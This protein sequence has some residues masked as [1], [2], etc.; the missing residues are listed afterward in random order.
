MTIQYAWF[1]FLRAKGPDDC[2][3][4]SRIVAAGLCRHPC[5]PTL[6]LIAG[7]IAIKQDDMVVAYQ[8][9]RYCIS[10]CNDD[11]FF[12][13][14]L[15]VIYYK[16]GQTQDA[17]IAFQRALYLKGEMSEP[18]LNIGLIFEQQGDSTSAQKIYQT[19]QTKC[20]GVQEFAERLNALN[21]VQRRPYKPGNWPLIDVDDLKF[22]RPPAEAFARDYV[23]AVPELPPQCFGINTNV[24]GFKALATFPKSYFV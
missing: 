5:D 8:Q 15:G 10:Y 3:S 2:G 9:Y 4:V 20:P 11:P 7:R 16:N 21:G 14:G 19:G 22:I 6:L 24:E 17:V 1:V 23:A 13:C 12:W 18:W